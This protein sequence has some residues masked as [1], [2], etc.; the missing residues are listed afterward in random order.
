MLAGSG[1]AS[2]ILIIY[3]EVTRT[4]VSEAMYALSDDREDQQNLLDI[5]G[6]SRYKTAREG[7]VSPTRRPKM[8]CNERSTFDHMLDCYKPRKEVQRGPEAVSFTV[9]MAKVARRPKGKAPLP[10][11]GIVAPETRKRDAAS[12]NEV[13]K[14][15]YKKARRP[16]TPK[17]EN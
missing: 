11:L 2:A 10:F 15:S 14:E 5:I 16:R 6:A 12:R 9:E 8:Y 17:K 3:L 7:R 4:I 1:S 13:K